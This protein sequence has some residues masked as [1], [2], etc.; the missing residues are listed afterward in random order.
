MEKLVAL[1]TAEVV[2]KMRQA[3]EEV[4]AT[5]ESDETSAPLPFLEKRIITEK[6]LKERLSGNEGEIRVAK[7]SIITPAAQDWLKEH[8]ITV[9]RSSAGEAL[10][11]NG[12]KNISLTLFAP[13]C[14][15]KA[16][17]IYVD[18]IRQ[19]GCNAQLV[20][21]TGLALP[22]IL[23][24]ADDI[25][26]RVSRAK[27]EYAIIIEEHIFQLNTRANR[28]EN[29]NGVICWDAASAAESFR[30]NQP[31]ILFVHNSILAFKTICDIIKSWVA[32]I[33][34]QAYTA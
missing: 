26:Q 11:R 15:L 17:G 14:S 22:N 28:L 32:K 34:E 24:K 8:R 7:K 4:S 6:D 30:Q 20:D 9:I 19:A 27:D 23:Q 31:N 25:F 2:K 12:A 29:V 10:H 18:I 21:V 16:R 5:T 33:Q 3:G 1:I 13:Q